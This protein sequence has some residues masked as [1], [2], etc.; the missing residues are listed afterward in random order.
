MIEEMPAQ[1]VL[2]VAH[3][4]DGRLA[5]LLEMIDGLLRRCECLLGSKRLG[6]LEF[7]RTVNHRLQDEVVRHC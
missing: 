2:R 5:A 6:C 7:M 1:V 3:V 4:G